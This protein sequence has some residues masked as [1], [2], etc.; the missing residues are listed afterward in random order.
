MT[1][2]SLLVGQNLAGEID[3]VFV[4]GTLMPGS[5]SENVAKQAGK[6]RAVEAY[7]EGMLLYHFEPEGYPGIVPQALS[8]PTQKPDA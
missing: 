8:Q 4:Y 1:G 2:Q 5:K 7:L 6:F 3:A